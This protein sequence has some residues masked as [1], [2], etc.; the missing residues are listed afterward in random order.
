MSTLVVDHY[1]F[2]SRERW[3]GRDRKTGGE[4]ER[5][6]IGKKGKRMR[7]RKRDSGWVGKGGR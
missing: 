4:R 1:V 7:R 6:R 3:G 5:E 2:K